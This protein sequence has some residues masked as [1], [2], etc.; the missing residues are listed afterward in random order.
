MIKKRFKRKIIF[1]VPNALY[2]KRK[3]GKFALYTS[4]RLSVV[5]LLNV[6]GES[7]LLYLNL[8]TGF[9]IA[10]VNCT[11]FPATSFF[12]IAKIFQ[13]VKTIVTL[14]FLQHFPFFFRCK[15]PRPLL[16][17]MKSSYFFYFLLY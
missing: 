17:I 10:A 2:N 15:I 1:V 16:A 11:V 12:E 7:L 6:K 13:A 5:P 9:L 8:Y 14:I 4:F 3:A